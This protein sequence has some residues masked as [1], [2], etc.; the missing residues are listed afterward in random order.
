M[1]NL[2][3]TYGPL[4]N[5]IQE[6]LISEEEIHQRVKQVGLAIS[7]DYLGRNPI[8]VGVLKGVLFFMG[9]L[10]REINIP[11]EIDFIAVSSYSPETREQG[12]VR[13]VKDLYICYKIY[14]PG[15]QPAWRYVCYLINQTIAWLRSPFDIE[16]LTCRIV[17]LWDTAWI[18][19]KNIATY[20]FWGC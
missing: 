13:L 16:G 12:Y 11:L 5:D 6:I 18:T 9:D 7:R 20:P 14:N 2:V 4:A 19:G 15:I 3:K 10:L 17:S 8:L 1:E